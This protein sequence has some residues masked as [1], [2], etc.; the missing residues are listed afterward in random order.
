MTTPDSML[1]AARTL[2]TASRLPWPQV[3]R[4]Y[5]DLQAM[6][7]LPISRGRAVWHAS[8]NMMV[9]LIIGLAVRQGAESAGALKE[10]IELFRLAGRDGSGFEGDWLQAELITLLTDPAAAAE[11]ESVVFEIDTMRAVV[12]RKGVAVPFFVPV[13][14]VQADGTL[15]DATHDPSPL[16]LSR[17]VVAGELFRALQAGVTWQLPGAPPVGEGED[18]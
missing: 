2:A 1:T 9:S 12:T 16:I 7:F 18:E 15:R 8:P 11:V 6:D 14:E 10:T 4:V 17:G 13:D 3:Q 5:R